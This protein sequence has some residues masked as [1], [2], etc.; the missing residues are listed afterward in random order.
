ML[1]YGASALGRR[2][3]LSKHFRKWFAEPHRFARVAAE[4]IADPGVYDL[5]VAVHSGAGSLVPS[6]FAALLHQQRGCVFVGAILPRPGRSGMDTVPEPR[7]E[8]L[9]G[10]AMD[11]YLSPWNRW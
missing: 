7:C 5:L 6:I 4:A 2:T 9:R 1:C 8:R 3:G 11:G 10:M